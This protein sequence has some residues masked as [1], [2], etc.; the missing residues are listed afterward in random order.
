MGP[1][2]APKGGATVFLG[3]DNPTVAAPTAPTILFPQG[4]NL[5]TFTIKKRLRVTVD[6]KVT[7]SARTPALLLAEAQKATLT[8]TVNQPSIKDVTNL[9]SV[10]PGG[11]HFNHTT[12]TTFSLSSL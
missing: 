10:I 6:T 8:V 1:R 9:V 11:F 2:T 12:S 3:T 4:A 7:L 5:G